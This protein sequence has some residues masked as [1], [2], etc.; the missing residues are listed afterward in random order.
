MAQTR[1]RST[2]E[3]RKEQLQQDP[4]FRAYWERTALARAVALALIGYRVKHRL[5]QTQLAEKLGVRQPQVARLEMGEH[6]P[7]LEMLQRLAR[8]LGLRFIVEVAPAGPGA[9]ASPLTLPAGVEVV[10]DVTADG[11][12]ILVAT[13]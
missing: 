1:L 8:T 5:T 12:R 10:E 6:T 2:T 9:P 4:E 11:S 7:S 13:G 3:I